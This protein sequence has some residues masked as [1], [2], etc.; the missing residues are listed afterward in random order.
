MTSLIK[1]AKMT[2]YQR[3][4]RKIKKNIYQKKRPKSKM[5]LGMNA[6]Q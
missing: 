6:L 4:G 5:N 1:E 2:S 3:K